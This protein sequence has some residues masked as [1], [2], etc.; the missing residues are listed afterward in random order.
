MYYTFRFSTL[1]AYDRYTY[2][3][4]L[5]DSAISGERQTNYFTRLVDTL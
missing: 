5:S 4:I 2:F 3:E 1:E